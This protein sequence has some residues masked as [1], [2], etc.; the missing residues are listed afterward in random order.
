M[1]QAAVRP[2]APA[3]IAPDRRLTYG[4]L[5]V[6]ARRIAASLLQQDVKP[7]ALVAV[8]MEKGWEQVAAVLGVLQS[9]A[10]YLPIDPTLPAER[11]AYLLSNGEVR[12]AV[13][14]ESWQSAEFWPKDV[15]RIVVN[16]TT[17]GNFTGEDFA[18]DKLSQALGGENTT[19][20]DLAYV[21]Y[22]SGSTGQPK[23]V[24][25]SHRA[26]VNTIL[27]MN[28]RFQIGPS[29]RV[30]ALSALSFDLSVYGIFGLL[31][32]GGAMVIP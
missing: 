28:E 25:I 20:D 32:T 11:I 22:T 7:N 19:T 27:D 14:Q 16:E 13:T 26:A 2:D 31:A 30:L 17:G 10:A 8:V 4:E 15:A 29:D 6:R 21:I 23:G 18:E 1:K 5:A 24:M 9:G 3:V 12:V